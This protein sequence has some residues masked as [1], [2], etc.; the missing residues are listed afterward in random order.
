MSH[1]QE[2]TTLQG[3]KYRILRVLGQGGFGITYLAE[4]TLLGKQVAIKEFYM[5]EFC[6]RGNNS[7]VTIAT[8]GSSE[9]VKRFGAKFLKEARSVAQFEHPNIVNVSDVFTENGTAYF[10]MD[11][12]PDGSLRQLLAQRGS[13]SESEAQGYIAQ[14]ASALQYIHQRKMNHLDVKPANIMLNKAGNPVLIDFGISKQYDATSGQQTSSTP[15]GISEGYAPIEQYKQGGLLEFSPESDVYALGATYYTLLTGTKPPSATD[16]LENGLPLEPL[17]AKG[18]SPATIAAIESAMQPSRRNRMKDVM[19]LVG[20]KSAGQTTQD[21][22]KETLLEGKPQ[23]SL[24]DSKNANRKRWLGYLIGGLLA[25]AIIVA[26]ILGVWKRSGLTKP[27]KQNFSANGVSFTMIAVKN[28][29]FTMGATSEQEDDAESDEKPIH[30]VTLNSY[31]LGETEVTRALWKAVMG[32]YNCSVDEG[33]LPV[34]HVD[35]STCQ[36]FIRR[37]NQLTGKNFRLPTEAEWEYAARGG[38][39]S[40]G[41][42]YSGSNNLEQVA[43]Y[44]GNSDGKTHPV[45]TKKANELGLYDMS[46]NVWEW[47]SDWYGE[48]SDTPQFIPQGATSGVA[49]V[50]RGG[51]WYN[52]SEDCR[53]SY[54]FN[55]TPSSNT[56]TQACGLRLALSE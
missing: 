39:K 4:H 20:T 54:R 22:G 10:V 47:C 1:L 17:K 16:V 35:W 6:N 30:N 23:P 56:N 13:L 5:K 12:L 41:Y 40:K 8:Q 31:Y 51:C 34:N 48:Y 50:R 44:E 42:K 3:G 11:H 26:I 43:W 49:R 52:C 2:N 21:K 7:H 15:V 25:T 28:G 18:V 29:D 53:V 45:K 9:I 32:D 19:E 27:Q 14:I 37:L 46:G 38:N 36:E 55:G 33:D 24:G